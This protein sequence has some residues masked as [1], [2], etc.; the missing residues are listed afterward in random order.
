MKI[1]IKLLLFIVILACAAPFL[2]KDPNGRPLL[3]MDKIPSLE[4]PSL[5][6]I[7]KKSAP[8][9]TSKIDQKQPIDLQVYKWIDKN[10]V[11]HYSEK[12][13]PHYN[14]KLAEIKPLNIV[15]AQELIIQEKPVIS[16]RPVGAG[17]TTI[18]MQDISKL[19]DDTKHVKEMMENRGSQI[20]RALR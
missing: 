5:T 10:G 3:D 17:L 9:L 11:T 2:L 4:L 15:P 18:P 1:F 19:M 13:S 14:S 7:K 12:N 16:N 20:D 6:D 8:L